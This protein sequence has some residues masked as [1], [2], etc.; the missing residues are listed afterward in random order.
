MFY[1]QNYHIEPSLA[2]SI[3]LLRL[4]IWFCDP[5]QKKG[6]RKLLTE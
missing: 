2:E 1:Q 6:D 4:A 3:S 5:K